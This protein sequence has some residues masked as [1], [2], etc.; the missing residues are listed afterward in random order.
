MLNVE[1][2]FEA[3]VY[4]GFIVPPL[5][6]G[7]GGAVRHQRGRSRRRRLLPADWHLPANETL[8][9]STEIL[10]FAQNDDPRG[11]GRTQRRLLPQ[12]AILHRIAKSGKVGP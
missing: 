9:A 12:V 8:S 1:Q 3:N 4:L 2:L 5:L 10:R 6:R 7:E 11:K